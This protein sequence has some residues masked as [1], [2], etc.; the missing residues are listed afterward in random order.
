MER[1]DGQNYEKPAE[2]QQAIVSAA[3]ELFLTSEKITMR[4]VMQIPRW[5]R[6]GGMIKILTTEEIQHA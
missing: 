3:G 2:R 1:K 5:T 4:D 6:K